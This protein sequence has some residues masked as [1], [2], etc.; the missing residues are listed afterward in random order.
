MKTS[1]LNTECALAAYVAGIAATRLAPPPNLDSAAFLIWSEDNAAAYLQGGEAM[2]MLPDTAPDAP[3]AKVLVTLFEEHV[4]YG[5]SRMLGA[6]DTIVAMLP[7]N[8]AP[9]AVELRSFA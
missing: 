2:E 9:H 5:G 6:M 3:L 8:L 4:A 7:P 1:P